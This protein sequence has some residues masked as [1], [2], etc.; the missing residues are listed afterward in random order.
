[1]RLIDADAL[2]ITEEYE[3]IED[4]DGLEDEIYWRYY[5]EETIEDAPTFEL[6]RCKE[7]KWLSGARLAGVCYTVCTYDSHPVQRGENDFCSRAER[8]TDDTD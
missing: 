8:R 4:E 3:W 1:M 5:A 2:E 7:C 6:V